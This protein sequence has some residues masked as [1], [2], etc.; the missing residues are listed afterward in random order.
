LIGKCISRS[1]LASVE[2]LLR[3]IGAAMLKARNIVEDEK[4]N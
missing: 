3:F 2:W 4:P 1:A